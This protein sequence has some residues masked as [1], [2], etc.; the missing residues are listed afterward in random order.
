[1]CALLSPIKI[2]FIKIHPHPKARSEK[3]NGA[4]RKMCMTQ[5][6]ASVYS[7]IWIWCIRRTYMN[8]SPRGI[9]PLRSIHWTWTYAFPLAHLWYIALAWIHLLRELNQIQAK[10]NNKKNECKLQHSKLPCGEQHSTPN[11]VYTIFS[12]MLKKTNFPL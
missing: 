3:L 5:R 9:Y 2:C 7:E 10:D 8:S 4:K 12:I 6:N 11:G 1:M